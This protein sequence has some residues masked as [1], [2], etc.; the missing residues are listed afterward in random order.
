MLLEGLPL[1]VTEERV[2]VLVSG[3]LNGG[4]WVGDGEN[5]LLRG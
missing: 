4:W 1:C 5:W 3:G 2:V